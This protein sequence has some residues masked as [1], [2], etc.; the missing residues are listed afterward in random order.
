MK[1]VKER[2]A[3]FG[4]VGLQSWTEQNRT[5]NPT[6]PKIKD[7]VSNNFIYLTRVKTLI[8]GHPVVF[9]MALLQLK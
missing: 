9:I 3:Y 5:P 2:E 8:T 6:P 7:E 4:L 1:E